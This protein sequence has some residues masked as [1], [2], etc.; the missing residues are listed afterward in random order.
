MKDS[1]VAPGNPLELD[2]KNMLLKKQKNL[3]I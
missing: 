1:A 2:G 3:P